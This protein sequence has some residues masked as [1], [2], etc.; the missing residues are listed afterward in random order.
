MSQQPYKTVIQM[1]QQLHRS[2]V[3]ARRST[4]HPLHANPTIRRWATCIMLTLVLFSTMEVQAQRRSEYEYYM[5]IP[6][7]IDSIQQSLT[8]PL[9][10]RNC[11][12]D[13]SFEQWRTT[14]RQK[15][16]ECMGTLPPRPAQWDME[17]LAR[18]QRK[19]YEAQL[20][21][22][23]L[24]RWYRVKAYLLIPSGKGKKPAVNLL[25]DHGGH[26]FIGKE[27]MI[28]PILKSPE[29]PLGADSAVLADA[30]KWAKGLYENQYLG[31]YLAQAGYVVFS[32]DAPLWG[33]RGRKEGADRN[34]YDIIAGNMMMLGQDLCA[35]MHH[36]DVVSTDFLASL[37]F[38]DSTRMGCAGCSMGAYRA[39]MLMAL[40]DKVRAG[41]A[42]CWMT[43]TD[44]QLT[45]RYG[46][47]E[48]GGF[49]NCIPALRNYLDYPDIASIAAPKAMLFVNGKRDKLFKIPG[50]EKAYAEMHEVWN[51]QRA[52][53]RLVTKLEDQ[54]HECNLHNQKDILNFLNK[55]LH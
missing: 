49:A 32:I 9:A 51:S 7:Y 26:F 45:T 52:G 23:N 2:R 22:F 10:F 53:D 54:P 55:W 41:A 11:M 36:D 44:A 17:V 30:D 31:D 33:E 14:A 40:T 43:T 24:S 13:M 27:K 35:Y 25:H 48:N 8:Y 29:N 20:I 6:V 12:N 19:G 39:W 37:P 5:D 1:S 4:S 42:I 28:R 3:N 47:R 34:K 16:L 46:R 38:V 18:E 21:A 15:V 50:V